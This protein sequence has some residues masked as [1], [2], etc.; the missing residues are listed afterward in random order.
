MC[1]GNR[2][3][4]ASKK[5]QKEYGRKKW[6]F[7][8]P[9]GT[10][11]VLTLIILAIPTFY[12]SPTR[13]QVDIQEFYTIGSRPEHETLLIL[14]N[15]HNMG[16]SQVVP[17]NFQITVSDGNSVSGP[18]N[19]IPLPGGAVFAI[20]PDDFPGDKTLSIP[21]EEFL[22]K[23]LT[24]KPVTAG[25]PVNGWMLFEAVGVHDWRNAKISLE[26]LDSIGKRGKIVLEN[27]R[28]IPPVP[29]NIKFHRGVSYP[30]RDK[31]KMSEA[32]K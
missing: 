31:N 13:V 23:R 19:T 27:P 15:I 26:F 16:E 29:E 12:T 8:F 28:R 22:E 9:T 18:F 17:E 10:A 1:L 32:I 4:V 11:S 21:G 5:I 14:A 6:T 24:D 25:V 30:F 3:A 2:E 20:Y 7:S